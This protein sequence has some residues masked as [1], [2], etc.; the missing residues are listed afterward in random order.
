MALH[1]AGAP[2]DVSHMAC[3]GE[4]QRVSP[5]ALTV[6]VFDCVRTYGVSTVQELQSSGHLVVVAPPGA[7]SMHPRKH[8]WGLGCESWWF[9]PSRTSGTAPDRCTRRCV[10]CKEK[11]QRVSP[12][13]LFGCLTEC[14]RMS[15]VST[16]SLLP[17]A[18]HMFCGVM[19]D[20]LAWLKGGCRQR[21]AALW[22]ISLAW[23]HIEHTPRLRATLQRA[24]VLPVG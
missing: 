16:V 6:R 18:T 3:Q 21:H 12:Q 9:R 14:M 5:Q 15:G 19:C 11:C 2:E 4:N 8:C 20:C 13:A 1:L 10:S 7:P 17:I 24:F 23:I 22:M